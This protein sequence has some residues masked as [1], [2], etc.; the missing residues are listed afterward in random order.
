MTLHSQTHYA[1]DRHAALA[2]MSGLPLPAQPEPS[3]QR[4]TQRVVLAPK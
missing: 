1:E 4:G 3:V 2:G